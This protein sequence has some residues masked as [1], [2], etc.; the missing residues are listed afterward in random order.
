MSEFS[1][2]DKDKLFETFLLFQ[3]Y[4]AQNRININKTENNLMIESISNINFSTN[5]KEKEEKEIKNEPIEPTIYK[6]EEPQVLPNDNIQI[7]VKKPKKNI[8]Q[9]PTIENSNP[10]TTVSASNFDDI[11]IKPKSNN[12]FDLLEKELAGDYQPIEVEDK[13]TK[14]VKKGRFKKV[15]NVSK[16][17]ETKKYRYYSDNFVNNDKKDSKIEEIPKEVIKQKEVEKP[18]IKKSNTNSKLQTK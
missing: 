8:L 14:I 2:I 4:M 5:N 7:F 16:P 13:S 12:F 10:T 6:T 3:T 1:S 9:K 11:P 18:K 15:V 17:T